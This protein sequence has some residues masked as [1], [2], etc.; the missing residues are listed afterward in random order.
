MPNGIAV[1]RMTPRYLKPWKTWPK[2]GIGREKP[3]FATD[4]V[5]PSRPM[6]PKPHPAAAE[7]QAIAEPTAIAT[8]PA[9]MPRYFTPP[10]QL[11]RMI[12]KQRSEERRVGKEC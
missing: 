6:P 10:N 5:R 2:A 12:A 4:L 9:G 7:I 11:A 3:K 8:R 1:T